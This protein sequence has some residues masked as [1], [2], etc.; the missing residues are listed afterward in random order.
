[1]KG[2]A[3]FQRISL[4]MFEVQRSMV[5][6]SHVVKVVRDFSFWRPVMSRRNPSK[7]R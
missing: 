3:E 1:M 6:W 5:R 7:N 2:G 4:S